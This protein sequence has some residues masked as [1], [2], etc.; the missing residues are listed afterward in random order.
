MKTFTATEAKNNF[1]VVLEAID[2]DVVEVEKNG[3]A[4]AYILSSDGFQALSSSHNLMRVRHLI[5][6]GDKKTWTS[7]RD[8]SSGLTFK[9]KTIRNLG[10]ENQSQLLDAMGFANLPLPSLPEAQIE[11]MVAEALADSNI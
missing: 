3:K 8:Y 5:L 7:L 9:G 10:L 11:T 4:A 6:S 1:G 2:T